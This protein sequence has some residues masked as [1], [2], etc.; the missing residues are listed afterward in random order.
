MKLLNKL[1]SLIGIKSNG[2]PAP[3]GGVYLNWG[4]YSGFDTLAH[5]P[6]E[7]AFQRNIYYGSA[8]VTRYPPV[9]RCISIISG[10]LARMPW[11]VEQWNEAAGIWG[12]APERS[13]F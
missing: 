10:D 1:S 13:K 4:P 5:E 8:D 11:G 2:E 7:G 9:Y 12:P 3:N 6:F